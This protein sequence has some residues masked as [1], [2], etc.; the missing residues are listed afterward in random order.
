MEALAHGVNVSVVFNTVRGQ[1]L[2]GYWQGYRVI[3]GDLHDVRFLD[4][5]GVVVG[6]RAKGEAKK[7]ASPFVLAS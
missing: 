1:A 7:V 3:D 6:L 2:P 5:R 4:P